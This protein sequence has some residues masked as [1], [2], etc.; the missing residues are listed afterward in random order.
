[1]TRRRVVAA[2]DDAPLRQGL[3]SLLGLVGLYS[4]PLQR[5][6]D[7]VLCRV[8]LDTSDH[9]AVNYVFAALPMLAVRPE[10]IGPSAPG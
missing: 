8:L 4:H 9:A 10:E 6:R 5:D 3:A 7:V 1:M 2:R